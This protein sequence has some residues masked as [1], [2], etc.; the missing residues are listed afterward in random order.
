M[1]ENMM[2]KSMC[3]RRTPIN[4]IH[5]TKKQMKKTD[6][7]ISNKSIQKCTLLQRNGVQM[8][9]RPQGMTCYPK[10]KIGSFNELSRSDLKI[11]T[12]SDRS[13]GDV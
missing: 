13:T 6:R 9:D 5:K 7:S 4:L 11:R 10:E 2:K 12:L 3:N 8:R 1:N